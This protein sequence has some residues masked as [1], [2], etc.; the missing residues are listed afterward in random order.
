M[1]SGNTLHTGICDSV[2]EDTTH[3]Y[4]CDAVS[5]HYMLIHMILSRNILHTGV[6]MILSGN[7]LHAVIC[8]AFW[9]HVA[10]HNSE[11]L[12]ILKLYVNNHLKPLFLLCTSSTSSIK[13]AIYF[14]SIYNQIYV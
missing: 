12:L 5:K 13:S 10:G 3:W 1:L 11:G 4:V 9:K 6:Y 8:D 7:I 14:L 2:W